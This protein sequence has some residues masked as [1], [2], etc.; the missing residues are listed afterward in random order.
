MDPTLWDSSNRHFR[1][2]I[3]ILLSH[4]SAAHKSMGHSGHYDHPLPPRGQRPRREVPSPPQGVSDSAGSGRARTLV[5]ETS[6]GLIGHPDD[7]KTGRGS[8]SIGSG[9]WRRPGSA[10]RGPPQGACFRRSTL[11]SAGN[12]PRQS[13]TGS[14]APPTDGDIR[15][16]API[17]PLARRFTDLLTCFRQER[18]RPVIIVFSLHRPLQGDHAEQH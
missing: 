9:V 13:Q 1:P 10:R 17:G 15:P 2:R 11:S 4:L 14:G 16:S 18:R 6:N 5:L 12:S 7:C 3:S 8:I